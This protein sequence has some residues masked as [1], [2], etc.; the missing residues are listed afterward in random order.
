M[1]K[2]TVV[3]SLLLTFLYV[4]PFYAINSAIDPAELQDVPGLAAYKYHP[5]FVAEGVH[6]HSG[7]Q[8]M[9]YYPIAALLASDMLNDNPSS[10]IFILNPFTYPAHFDD[11]NAVY[12]YS[13]FEEHPVLYNQQIMD[14]DASDS[15][16]SF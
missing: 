4:N 11:P 2:I 14:V 9:H 16:P 12:Y 5:T 15:E 10:Q 13:H 6:F 1:K 7:G 3:V 8:D